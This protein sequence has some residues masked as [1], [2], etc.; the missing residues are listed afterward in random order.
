MTTFRKPFF[1]RC[2]S[3]A[4]SLTCS[5]SAWAVDANAQEIHQR[6]V[7]TETPQA[8]ALTLDACSGKFDQKLVD[9]LVQER[10]PATLFVTQK[11][12]NKNPQAVALLQKHLDLFDV[13]NHGAQH[14]PAVIGKGKKVYGIAGHSDV[15]H[16]QREVENG[17]EAIEKAFHTPVHWYRAAT[18]RYDA[19][20][21]AAIEKMGFQVAGFSVNVDA[22]ATLSA[23]SIGK[24]V[25]Q[26]QAG[27]VLLA[28]M[29]K[30]A[31][32]TAKG[33]ADSLLELRQNGL[34]FVRLDHAEL[35]KHEST[36]DQRSPIN[37]E[38]SP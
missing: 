9:F 15:A 17:A 26:A 31:S 4:F 24:R 1:S 14:I 34:V 6:L 36:N 5:L 33:L 3:L 22:G 25:R 20:S 28:H 18:A 7:L 35:K 12:I 11:W 29:N 21:L 13:E 19:E 2:L 10:I 30:P 37:K 16:L 32:G 8:V 38:K 23:R 27:D